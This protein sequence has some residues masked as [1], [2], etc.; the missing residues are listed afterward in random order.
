MEELLDLLRTTDTGSVV[1]ASEAVPA[2]VGEVVT[3]VARDRGL[4]LVVAETGD[5]VHL[6]WRPARA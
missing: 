2:D 3:D 5:V 6:A 1:V 4:D